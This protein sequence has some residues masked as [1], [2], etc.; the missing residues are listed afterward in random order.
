M[1]TFRLCHECAC[2]V[3]NGD[4]SGRDFYGLT[5]EDE[6]ARDASIEA[7][8]LVAHV[9]SRDIGC[10]TC[11]VCDEISYGDVEMFESV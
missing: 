7:M 3:A 9:D 2:E 11:F 5:N 1:S 10:F 6:A 8:G 4:T